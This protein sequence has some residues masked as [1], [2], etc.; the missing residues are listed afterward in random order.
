MKTHYAVT[1]QQKRAWG[2]VRFD[3]LT[4]KQAI[5]IARDAKKAKDNFKMTVTIWKIEE[6]PLPKA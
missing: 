6:V 2:E 3:F 5:K 4:H 1:Y